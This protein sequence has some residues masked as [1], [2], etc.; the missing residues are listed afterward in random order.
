MTDIWFQLS[1]TSHRLGRRVISKPHQSVLSPIRTRNHKLLSIQFGRDACN[2]WTDHRSSSSCHIITEFLR[3]CQFE[4]F[5]RMTA[6]S[7][8][9]CDR[10]E[11][12]R[13]LIFIWKKCTKHLGQ[14]LQLRLRTILIDVLFI[15]GPQLPIDCGVII[16]KLG[17]CIWQPSM[18]L[19]RLNMANTANQFF[20]HI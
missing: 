14:F 16:G 18:S 4:R 20:Y 6:H 3:K 12:I 1:C 15:I 2:K 8:V 13:T 9:M 17:L 7:P 11:G 5:L 10:T 19:W